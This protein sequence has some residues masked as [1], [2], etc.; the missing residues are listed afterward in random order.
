MALKSGIDVSTSKEPDTKDDQNDDS[1]EKPISL[2]H[3]AIPLNEMLDAAKKDKCDVTW[4]V[5]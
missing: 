3:R 5:N 1:N 2:A 4:K